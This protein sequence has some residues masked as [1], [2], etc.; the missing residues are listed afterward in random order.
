MQFISRSFYR[1]FSI[2]TN[3]HIDLSF[4]IVKYIF[5]HLFQKYRVFGTLTP[6]RYRKIAIERIHNP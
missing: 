2:L 3:I 4:C 1:F 5:E 6:N